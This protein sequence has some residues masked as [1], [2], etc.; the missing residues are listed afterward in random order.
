MGEIHL[1]AGERNRAID[2]QRKAAKVTP[3]NADILANLGFNVSLFGDPKIG[4]PLVER[5]MRISLKYP[6]WY[7]SA[8]GRTYYMMGDYSRAIDAPLARHKII[9]NSELP[10]SYLLIA[11]SAAGQLEQA[12]K[13]AAKLRKIV[14]DYTTSNFAD[15]AGGW[16]KPRTFKQII[17]HMEAAGIENDLKAKL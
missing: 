17:A 14:P 5:A 12:R 15:L 6:N 8:L 16:F 1:D 13:M 7:L 2:L 11:Y 10:I 9:P 4:L 3:N